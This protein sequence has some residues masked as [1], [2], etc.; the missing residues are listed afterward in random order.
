MS[1]LRILR[2]LAAVVII[3]V[4]GLSL[5]PRLDSALTFGFCESNDKVLTGYCLTNLNGYGCKY[6]QCSACPAGAKV[7]SPGKEKC[8]L[9]LGCAPPVPVDLGRVCFCN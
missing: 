6:E 4:G 9:P 8:C 3:S 1:L 2:N 5:T 7:K